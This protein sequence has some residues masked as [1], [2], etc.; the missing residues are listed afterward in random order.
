MPGCVVS[1]AGE[2]TDEHQLLMRIVP[3]STSISKLSKFSFVLSRPSISLASALYPSFYSS[4][5]MSYLANKT[6]RLELVRD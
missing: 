4:R 3:R 6:V 2:P 5:T 1:F